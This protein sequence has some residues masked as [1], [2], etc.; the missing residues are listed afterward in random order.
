MC[1]SRFASLLALLVLTAPVSARAQWE[2][3]DPPVRGTVDEERRPAPPPAQPAEPPPKPK[4]ADPEP[5]PEAAT[6][7]APPPKKD[8]KEGRW[9]SEDAPRARS[10][11]LGIGGAV[12][13]LGGY[14]FPKITFSGSPEARF[15]AFGLGGAFTL[16]TDMP[17]ADLDW[18]FGLQ[19]ALPGYLG[20]QGTVGIK[21]DLGRWE[22]PK[23]TARGG[24]GLELMVAGRFSDA[25]GPGYAYLVP[26]VLGQG[27]TAIDFDVVPNRVRLG[28]AFELA[29]R[30]G[31]PIGFGFNA[32][33]WLRAQVLY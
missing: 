27:E 30:L 29:A 20:L 14:A 23:I 13:T 22:N 3:D 5:A 9:N 33:G 25:T 28:G 4:P 31:L 19:G 21:K 15:R 11:T 18:R 12:A 7:P 17:L 24:G 26:V 10:V 1:R 2:E 32:A 16:H 6:T 8:D